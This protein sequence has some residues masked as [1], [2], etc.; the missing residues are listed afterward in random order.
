MLNNVSI[1]ENVL[2][3]LEGERWAVLPGV[4]LGAPLL[5]MGT[6]LF[7]GVDYPSP[8]PV[9]CPRMVTRSRGGCCCCCCCWCW[10]LA[11]GLWKVGEQGMLS[12]WPANSWDS[13]LR[14]P[15]CHLV[16]HLW[17]LSTLELLSALQLTFPPCDLGCGFPRQYDSVS[18]SS[19]CKSS[20]FLPINSTHSCFPALLWIY[21]FLKYQIFW[22]F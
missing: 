4:L 12:C 2:S 15:C 16:C 22:Y 1:Y 17:V 14:T 11:V 6:L 18:L 19:F 13:F 20:K 8:S 3:L 7:L 21:S 9:Y 10:G 5:D